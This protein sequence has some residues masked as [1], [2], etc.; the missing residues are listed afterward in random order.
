MKQRTFALI[1]FAF[2]L[3]GMAN[4]ASSTFTNTHVVL[5][6]KIWDHVNQ[7]T[8]SGCLYD[9]KALLVTRDINTY[10]YVDGTY[11]SMSVD[12]VDSSK[13]SNFT[14]SSTLA[15]D[16]QSG[17]WMYLNRILTS[18]VDAFIGA[19]SDLA[20]GFTNI[21]SGK[22]TEERDLTLFGVGSWFNLKGFQFVKGFFGFTE[23]VEWTNAGQS[24][25]FDGVSFGTNKW[26]TSGTYTNSD[27]KTFSDKWKLW[28]EAKTIATP[29]PL[30]FVLM[31][32]GLVALKFM[33]RRMKK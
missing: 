18:T 28:D 20:T 9:S 30:S 8:D 31:G 15:A 5:F 17:T 11:S 25:W 21:Y 23:D 13:K 6:D 7:C 22:N 14:S 24:N 27:F 10:G 4:G 33:R 16:G 29:E 19:A 12:V 3:A 1:L 32:S 26:D 2:A